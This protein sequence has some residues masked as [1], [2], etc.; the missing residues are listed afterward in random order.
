MKDFSPELA[1]HLAGP[2][3]TLCACWKITRGD[4]AALGF[5]DHDRE[6]AFGG[7]AYRPQDGLSATGAVANAGMEV[8][9]LEVAGALT[10]ER[11][12]EADLAAGLYDNARVEMWLVNWESPQ[13]RHLMRIAEIGEVKR[14][15][16]AFTA[17]LRSLSHRLDQPQGRLFSHL[18]DADLGDARCGVAVAGMTRAANVT[19][20]DGAS[21]VETDGLA[22]PAGTFSRGLLT[23]TSGDNAGRKM[24]VTRHALAE[25]GTGRARLSLWQAMEKD[26]AVGDAF[27]VAPGCDKRFATCQGT[28]GNAA[29]FRGFPHMP[30]NDFAWATAFG[31]GGTSGGGT[32]P[33]A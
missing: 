26:I 17:E 16:E 33:N 18:C 24:E 28:F 15:G 11:L 20:T 14:E 25:A 9:G 30:G 21:F 6:I 8:G 19:A 3:T 31:G 4:G 10:S 22:D 13:E 2:I 23:F 5:T 7:L 32:A 12:A 27:T 29:N 1:D